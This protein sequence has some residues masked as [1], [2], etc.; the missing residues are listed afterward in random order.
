MGQTRMAGTVGLQVLLEAPA[1]AAHNLTP[2]VYPAKVGNPRQRATE[3]WDSEA[4]VAVVALLDRGL[5]GAPAGVAPKSSKS[6]YLTEP[7]L[8]HRCSLENIVYLNTFR[9]NKHCFMVTLL[10]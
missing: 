7:C 4:E 9:L 6:V 8:I 10:N 2:C 1:Q 3:C 5:Q